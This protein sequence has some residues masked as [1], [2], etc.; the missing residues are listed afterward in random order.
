MDRGVIG[1]GTNSSI[2]PGKNLNITCDLSVVMHLEPKPEITTAI[3]QI[4]LSYDIN[5]LWSDLHISPNPTPFTWIGNASNPQWVRGY[6]A[7]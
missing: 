5:I 7:R 4:S 2:Q 1:F 6:Y 3:I